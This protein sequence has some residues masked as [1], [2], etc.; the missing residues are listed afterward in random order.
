MV[1]GKRIMVSWIGHTDI[2]MLIGHLSGKKQADAL[3][4]SKLTVPD[5]VEDGPVK[6][7][8]NQESFDEIHLLSNYPSKINDLYLEW[9]G[10]H[11]EVHSFSLENPTDY[12]SIY[13]I[14]DSTLESIRKK[15]PSYSAKLCINLSP[16][17]PAM[18]AVWILLGKT[19]YP[20][21]FYQT[22]HSTVI[23][24]T[25]PFDISIDYLPDYLK[26]TD[27][28][29]HHLASQNPQDIQGFEA[30][31]GKSKAIKLAAGRASKA[32]IRD[33]N[34][35]LLGES[36][37][38]KEVF[39][40]AIHKGSR[41]SDKPFRAINCAA[42]P[43]ELLESELF[44]H[45]KG[46]FTGADKNKDGL[47]KLADQ[48]TLFLDEIGECDLQV[49]AKLLRVLQPPQG[50]PLSTR[51][52]QPVGSSKVIRSDVRI[53]AA[54]N[55]NL[56][57]MVQQGKFR[58]DLYYR[59]AVINV[60]LPPLRERQTDIMDI[61]EAIL[62]S[63]NKDFKAQ[64][65]NHKDKIISVGAKKFMK[66]YH[67]P[68]NVRELSNVLLQAM[69]MSD[70]D[71]LSRQDLESSIAEVPQAESQVNVLTHPLGDEF[72]L[73]QLL[74]EVQTHYLQRAMVESQGVKKKAAELLGM[75]NYQTLDSQIKR[76]G[77]KWE[78]AD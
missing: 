41:R 32:A 25:I 1:D 11:A 78:K 3:K 33:V 4:L 29:I 19:K 53:V 62:Y 6:T 66:Q 42:I 40:Q 65:S 20:A 54:T 30:I 15:S 70:S 50:K 47:F 5:S 37:T 71:K 10:S 2:R 74:S 17:T 73:D 7:L 31:V 13:E 52:F 28:T 8:I 76:L 44:G 45:T 14:A 38:G 12:T 77:I 51:E 69:V 22:H 67:W 39:A 16:G 60:H 59:L 35:L 23:E 48:G 9:L 61:A 26:G 34:I 75:N 46:A 68:G 55:R 18:A 27:S 58:E 64:D 57:E 49:Q 43:T 72:S 24:T 56:L 21:T 63:Y 36:G